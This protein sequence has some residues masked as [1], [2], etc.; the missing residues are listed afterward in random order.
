MLPN[1]DAAAHL[2]DFLQHLYATYRHHA[3]STAELYPL[4]ALDLG[5]SVL[6]DVSQPYD[7]MPL[8]VV[9]I[10]PTQAGK[11]TVVNLLL[12]QAAA[13]VSPLA[14]FTRS[15]G[16]YAVN[17]G[18]Q[19]RRTVSAFF[20]DAKPELNTVPPPNNGGVLAATGY[21]VWD[22]PDF[23][24]Y[25]AK[26]YRG[27][28]ARVAA[29]ADLILLVVSKE[30]YSDLS[31]WQVMDLLYPLARPTVI[32]LNKLGSDADLLS[33]AVSRRLAESRYSPTN[34]P[35]CPLPYWNT[36]NFPA[37]RRSAQTERLIQT[38][39][40][41]LRRVDHAARRS[42]ARRLL[43]E[44]WDHWLE[45]VRAELDSTAQWRQ[46][47]LRAVGDAID[48]YRDQ[49]LEHSIHNG[50]FQKAMVQLLE[51]IE[52][53]GIAKPLLRTRQILTWPL[54][55]LVAGL[56]GSSSSAPTEDMELETLRQ[57]FEHVTLSLRRS[58]GDGAASRDHSAVWWSALGH[59]YDRRGSEIQQAFV[60]EI[61]RYQDDFEAE[62]ERAARSL[63]ARLQE[64]PVTL[65]GLR[66]ARVTT[67]AAGVALA[68]K[69]GGLGVNELALTPA[70][71]SL[72]SYLAETAVGTYLETVKT[73]LKQRQLARVD[74]V[75]SSH[76]RQPLTALAD[77]LDDERL[78][79]VD[80]A[81]LDD[82]ERDK[83]VL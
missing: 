33:A 24:S 54:R 43:A 21:I 9:V 48:S 31:V 80:T 40:R 79:R 60:A 39:A 53:P 34:V 75:M 22:T 56:T 2:H 42:G 18:G 25:I 29:L 7:S 49:Y 41:R 67:D 72:T 17:T 69:T 38:V 74:R 64:S 65:N 8:N 36:G 70:M 19:E 57:C 30:K 47:V 27:R 62:I 71:L 6:R 81:R 82:A 58:I 45:P 3:G 37:L 5:T 63:Y 51:L 44:H 61:G 16:A 23:D 14:G 1:K 83:E 15:L 52:I 55:R 68:F 78:F 59:A 12:G 32:C 46:A 50:T 10:G 73:Q 20:P 66:V 11:S 28:I 4:D 76:C 35:V 26:S 13:A 77:G